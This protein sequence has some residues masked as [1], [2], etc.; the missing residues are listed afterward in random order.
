MRFGNDILLLL[1][2]WLGKRV[3]RSWT[4]TPSHHHWRKMWL[5]RRFHL[6]SWAD[7]NALIASSDLLWNEIVILLT[8]KSWE[9]VL[10][11]GLLESAQV[12]GA[13]VS[14]ILR[15][16]FTAEEILDHH[17]YFVVLAYQYNEQ[18]LWCQICRLW[19]L[20][21]PAAL[22]WAPYAILQVPT[23]CLFYTWQCAYAYATLPIH[24]APLLPPSSSS[25][26]HFSMSVFL[27][28]S[29]KGSLLIFNMTVGI[30]NFTLEVLNN[31][32]GGKLVS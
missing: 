6:H 3:H 23:N 13:F 29:C 18:F 2:G 17:T 19:H 21:Y 5:Q 15:A 30:I 9:K 10:W 12:H 32:H 20:S 26:H 8:R 27:F 11:M 4:R 14:R 25:T 7:V 16:A 24:P 28:L 1:S 22:S 31:H